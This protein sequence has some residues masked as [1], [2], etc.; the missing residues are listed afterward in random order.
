MSRRR[1]S[2][3]CR[4]YF[5]C[6]GAQSAEAKRLHIQIVFDGC[7][8]MPPSRQ[9]TSVN[10]EIQTIAVDAV[11]SK[12]CASSN[13]ADFARLIWRSAAHCEYARESRCVCRPS[14]ARASWR[15]NSLHP[16]F[17]EP[18]ANACFRVRKRVAIDILTKSGNIRRVASRLTKVEIV[19][20]FF[21]CTYLGLEA[22]TF[23]QQAA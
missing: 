9:E 14:S 3:L 7:D 2:E 12:T 17:C 11:E 18:P 8:R 15:A 21:F 13:A 5:C 1:R 23:Q 20:A 4:R 6:G 19:F 10:G 16:R 22:F